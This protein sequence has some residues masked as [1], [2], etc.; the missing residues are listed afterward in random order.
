MINKAHAFCRSRSRRPDSGGV[1]EKAPRRITSVNIFQGSFYDLSKAEWVGECKVH[2]YQIWG[3]ASIVVPR[4][5]KVQVNGFALFG[6]F[7]SYEEDD[8]VPLP[9]APT[10]TVSGFNLFGATKIRRNL[11]LSPIRHVSGASVDAAAR[12]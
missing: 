2:S 6:S 5:V 3:G 4:G 1:K 10:I 7:R 11:L 12:R 9:D 8:I